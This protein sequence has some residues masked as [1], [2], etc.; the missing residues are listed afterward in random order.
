MQLEKPRVIKTNKTPCPL[1]IVAATGFDLSAPRKILKTVMIER[2][3][4]TKWCFVHVPVNWPFL[5]ILGCY[6]HALRSTIS[7]E[8]LPRIGSF[9]DRCA[10][11][12]LS[13]QDG[14]SLDFRASS[15]KCSVSVVHCCRMSLKYIV[16]YTLFLSKVWEPNLKLVT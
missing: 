13:L 5:T 10:L 2:P 7:A 12:M 6:R 16:C 11:W 9:R 4:W 8:N 3:P 14:G 15:A 1:T